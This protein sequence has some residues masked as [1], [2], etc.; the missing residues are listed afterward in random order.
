[1]SCL[2]FLTISKQVHQNFL[3]LQST[4]K[5]NFLC[6]AKKILFKLDT[7]IGEDE[8]SDYVIEGDKIMKQKVQPTTEQLII[9]NSVSEQSYTTTVNPFE[10]HPRDQVTTEITNMDTE[11]IHGFQAGLEEL[12]QQVTTTTET[13]KSNLK[14][15]EKSQPP[16]LAGIYPTR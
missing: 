5:V 8:E 4:V 9:Q 13:L 1:M 12:I 15:T 16:V 11:K 10:L 7:Q 3:V 2:G 14:A 6:L